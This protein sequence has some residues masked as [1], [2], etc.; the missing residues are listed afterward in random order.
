MNQ[1][2]RSSSSSYQ[3]RNSASGGGDTVFF[4]EVASNEEGGADL[5]NVNGTAQGSKHF[6]IIEQQIQSIP[7]IHKKWKLES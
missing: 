3:K 5:Q 1:Q 4:R 7:S 6:L 2:Q